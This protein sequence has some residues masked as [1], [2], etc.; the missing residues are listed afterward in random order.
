MKTTIELLDDVKEI[1]TEFKYAI[2]AKKLSNSLNSF[3][4]EALKSI[5]HLTNMFT[6]SNA[7]MF[8]GE[9][10]EFKTQTPEEVTNDSVRFLN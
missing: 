4:R 5:T 9:R 7:C 3:D 1:T 8:N 2:L 6:Y 10:I